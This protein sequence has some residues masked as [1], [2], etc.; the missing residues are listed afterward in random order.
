MSQDISI[1]TAGNRFRYRRSYSPSYSTGGYTPASLVRAK[2]YVARMP[3]VQ[4]WARHV[5]PYK[6]ADGS[7]AVSLRASYVPDLRDARAGVRGAA[8]T[9]RE[10]PEEAGGG[11]AAVEERRGGFKKYW[12]GGK[13]PPAGFG[14][15]RARRGGGGR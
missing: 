6:R 9:V 13:N 12:G 3:C 8:G 15:A 2:G 7:R 10:E 11:G 1:R 4:E 14:V 5:V